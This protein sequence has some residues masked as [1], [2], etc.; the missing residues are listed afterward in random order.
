MDKFEWFSVIKSSLLK[1]SSIKYEIEARIGRI[2]NKETES[3]MK[4]L[5]LVPVVF[6]KLPS[7]HSFVPG[8]DLWDFKSLKK[9]LT[10]SSFK[11]VDKDTISSSSTKL[12][13]DFTI[14][15]KEHIEDSF[16]YL[17]NGNRIR[18]INNEYRFCEKKCKIQV[19]DLYLPDYKYDVRISIMTEEKQMQRHTQSPVE[20]VRHRDRDTFTDK[21]FNYDFTV[22]RKNKEV[23]YE[24]EIEVEDLNYKV[25]E[26]ITTFTKMNILNN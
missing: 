3:R 2:Y 4:L 20:F 5:S 15:F 24:I 25:E 16:K 11:K 14:I 23:T 9:D 19:L 7:Q 18:F 1:Y 17:R 22:V 13:K 26:F 8:V 6:S 21:W 12:D 10:N